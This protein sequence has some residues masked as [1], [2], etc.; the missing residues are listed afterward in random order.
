MTEMHCFAHAVLEGSC[1]ARC[2]WL[3]VIV[4]WF[5][6]DGFWYGTR[7]GVLHSECR[8]NSVN[9]EGFALQRVSILNLSEIHRQKSAF[10][11]CFVQAHCVLYV[12]LVFRLVHV[13]RNV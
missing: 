5:L 7:V 1:I 9:K 4:L 2:E 3:I 10:I 8:G 11:A 12:Q 6:A 13:V